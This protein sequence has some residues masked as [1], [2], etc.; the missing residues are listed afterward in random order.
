MSGELKKLKIKAVDEDGDIVVKEGKEMIY[1]ALVNPD[2]YKI[3]HQVVYN[4]GCPPQGSSGQELQYSH[5]NPANL[6]FDF[7]FDSTGVIPKPL[8]GLA[9]ALSGIPIAGAIAGAL[10]DQPK[11]DILDEIE[12]FKKIV[13]NYDGDIHEPRKVQLVWGTLFFEARLTSLDF[14]YKLFNPD[15]SPVR[16]VATANFRGTV[17]DDLRF[18]LENKQSPDV[19][20]IR[21]VKEGD[22]LPLM[23]YKIYGDASFYLEVARV[24]KLVNFR[25]LTPGDE[26][27]F[28]PLNKSK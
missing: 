26:I 5:T 25:N 1:I 27:Y 24:N 3:T 11:Y 23:T 21:K 13:L 18:V 15:G 7:L 6:Q 8:E 28:P 17:D 4:S 10:S 22:T 2:T 19:T 14:N 20:H 9:G 16:V 12:T